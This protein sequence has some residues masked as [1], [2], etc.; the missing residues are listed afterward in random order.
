VTDELQL[1]TIRTIWNNQKLNLPSMYG[2][3]DIHM[4]SSDEYPV[5]RKGHVLARTWEQ[6]ADPETA[7]MLI[8]DGD[9]AVDPLDC[10][11]MG[12]AIKAHPEIVHVAPIRLWPA[13]THLE[14]WVWG[15][16][17]GQYSQGWTKKI[18]WFTFGF[19]YLPA[20]LIVLA[21]TAGLADWHYPNV[22]KRVCAVANTHGIEVKLVN[23]CHPK[24]CN[25]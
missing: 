12:D 6:L 3:R 15:H 22:D 19:T 4:N 11:A 1:V 5:G 24:H 10:G 7:G 16:G 8:L 20:R 21:I 2:F 9:V 17:W 23:D 14:T 18:N 25:F 13:S